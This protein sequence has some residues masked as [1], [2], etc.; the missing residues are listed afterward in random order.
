MA[1]GHSVLIK[2][3]LRPQGHAKETTLRKT[4]TPFVGFVKSI[5]R[6][7]GVQFVTKAPLAWICGQHTLL[8]TQ[9]LTTPRL[10]SWCPDWYYA[11][12]EMQC[13]PLH[14][15]VYAPGGRLRLRQL[16]QQGH[17]VHR[18]PAGRA[19][20]W[21]CSMC[22]LPG[23]L[24]IAV[25]S[26]YARCAEPAPRPKSLT[27][28]AFYVSVNRHIPAFWTLNWRLR[29]YP[30]GPPGVRS[31]HVTPMAPQPSVY[32]QYHAAAVQSVRWLGSRSVSEVAEK[33]GAGGV[34]LYLGKVKARQLLLGQ[35]VHHI[36]LERLLH[37]L[38]HSV[39]LCDP[40]Y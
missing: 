6:L 3:V 7:D 18:S 1:V 8:R 33:T 14:I 34:R 29:D 39:Y 30:I 17:R 10:P 2:V 9:S 19:H 21:S 35:H 15:T 24:W 16:V 12:L 38:H 27:A 23:S 28:P 4:S 20:A 37:C 31:M 25:E 5:E 36:P 40:C 11:N 13:C 32:S 26:L 22:M